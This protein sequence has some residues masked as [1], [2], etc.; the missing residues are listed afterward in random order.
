[1]RRKIFGAINKAEESISLESSGFSSGLETT[2]LLQTWLSEHKDVHT[3]LENGPRT[4]VQLQPQ[5]LSFT[6]SPD[7]GPASKSFFK[8]LRAHIAQNFGVTL[9]FGPHYGLAEAVVLDEFARSFDLRQFWH[10]RRFKLS[11]PQNIL[12]QHISQSYALLCFALPHL[13]TL[14]N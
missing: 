1:M 7:Y 9:N 4:L 12:E 13:T 5:V 11:S 3:K 8:S 2:V 14:T 10:L 6:S